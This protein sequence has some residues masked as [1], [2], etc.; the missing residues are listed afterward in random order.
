MCDTPESSPTSRIAVI[1]ALG[2][3]CLSVLGCNANSSA[4]SEKE[5]VRLAKEHFVQ[6]FPHIG[7]DD[8]YIN[9]GPDGSWIAEFRTMDGRNDED[10]DGGKTWLKSS[11][12]IVIDG[13]GN[14]AMKSD[15]GS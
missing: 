1:L 11:V 13:A 10:L 8:V 2:I 9:S 7:Y 15:E 5:A 3:L 12:F 4:V 6:E 14:C